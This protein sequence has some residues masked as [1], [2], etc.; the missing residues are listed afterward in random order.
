[1]E[2]RMKKMIRLSADEM[3]EAKKQTRAKLNNY[4]EKND[5]GRGNFLKAI[6]ETMRL[7]FYKCFLKTAFGVKH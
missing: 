4:I 3:A 7:N 1:M 6:P 5:R 2:G